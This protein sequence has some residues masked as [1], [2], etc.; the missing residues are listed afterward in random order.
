M[1]IFH[2]YLLEFRFPKTLE[3]SVIYGFKCTSTFFFTLQPDGKM[4]CKNRGRSEVN[5]HHRNSSKNGLKIDPN[6]LKKAVET[7]TCRNAD[8]KANRAAQFYANRASWADLGSPIESHS[9]P[10]RGLRFWFPLIPKTLRVPS[11]HLGAASWLLGLLQV[12]FRM[13][14]LGFFGSVGFF[15]SNF[16]INICL[17]SVC[18]N[19][20]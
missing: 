13:I 8:E 5:N 14:L 11:G 20:S 16:V 4:R 12:T 15:E 7:Q 18:K 9:R 19:L 1:I 2:Q 3:Y 17:N 10:Q 6:R